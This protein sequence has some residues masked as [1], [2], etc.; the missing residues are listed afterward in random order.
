[1]RIT[2][3]LAAIAVAGHWRGPAS[4]ILQRFDRTRRHH[5]MAR[6]VNTQLYWHTTAPSYTPLQTVPENSVYVS[7]DRV[8]EFVQSFLA[9]SHG[10]VV[11]DD[12]HAPGVE[13]GRPNEA[14]RRIRIYSN[15]GKLMVLATDGNLPNPFGRETSGYEV[16]NL[17]NTLAKAK[18]AGAEILI[19][20]YAA[21]Q[22]DA[23][24]GVQMQNRY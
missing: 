3:F 18:A 9:F 24:P 10:K 6:R 2:R 1:M 7:A 16:A 12:A 23:A 8:A 13:I 17:A 19:G 14:F 22:G 15:L 5:P 20:P 21:E 11:S 4:Y